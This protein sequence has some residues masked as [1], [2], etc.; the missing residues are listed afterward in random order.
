MSQILHIRIKKNYATSILKELIK[1][2]AIETVE[3]EIIDLTDE[4]K[5]AIDHELEMISTDSGYLK[6][7]NEVRH[8]FKRPQ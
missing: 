8:Q 2:D 3:E 1:E 6:N 4:Q 7:W 5:K